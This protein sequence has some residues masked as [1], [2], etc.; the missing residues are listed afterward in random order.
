MRL[1]RLAFPL[2]CIAV[3]AT[4][5]A[6]GAQPAPVSP[7]DDTL[8]R[9]EA[10]LHRPIT[11]RP[12]AEFQ[13]IADPKA[14]SVALFQEAGKVIQHPRCVNCHPVDGQP[15]QGLEARIHNPPIMGGKK[16]D[17]VAGVKCST[18]HGVANFEVEG[19]DTR[20]IPGAPKWAL[21]PKEMAWQGKSLGEIC[22]QIKDPG[23]NHGK[24][25]TELQHHFAHD[26]LVGWS[27]APGEGRAPAPG[28]QA[29]LGELIQAWIDTGAICP[30]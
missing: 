8:A 1:L 25:L 18:C 13:S 16:G 6:V 5:V 27:W 22:R 12:P 2:A 26:P 19:R 4:A 24:T 15:R 29:R 20:S 9:Q 7:E 28:T 21:A 10:A 17:G 23:R 11:V 3:A 14:R 30:A